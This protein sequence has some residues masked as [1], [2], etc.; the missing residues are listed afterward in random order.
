[1]MYC[2][3]YMPAG[4]GTW[5]TVLII[6]VGPNKHSYDYKEYVVVDGVPEPLQSPIAP[7]RSRSVHWWPFPMPS[8]LGTLPPSH[9]K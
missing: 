1:M 6:E 7:P 4:T 5:R 8:E 2:L 9:E 3:P